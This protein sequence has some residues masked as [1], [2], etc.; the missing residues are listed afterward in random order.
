MKVMRGVRADD[1]ETDDVSSLHAVF[2]DANEDDTLASRIS[3]SIRRRLFVRG[4]VRVGRYL[5]EE[6]LDRGGL[7]VVWRGRDPDLARPVAIK[8]HRADHPADA[9]EARNSML[10]E[11][12]ALAQVRHP[13]VLAVFDVGLWSDDVYLVSELLRGRTLAT[14]LE[15][16][17]R[18]R[19]EIIDVFVAA[20]RGLAA[21][22]EAGLVH[23][24]F[25]PQN[26][27]IVDDGTP[28]VIDF[29]LAA[30]TS[31]DV[32]EAAQHTCG[33][34]TPRYMAPEQMNGEAVDA[35]ADVFAFCVSLYVALTDTAPFRGRT[36]RELRRAKLAGDLRPPPRGT[37]SR[38][39]WSI[40]RKG[41][42]SDPAAR[43]RSMD[44]LL[45]RLGRRT[46]SAWPIVAGVA[47]AIA[48]VGAT[49]AVL[50]ARDASSSCTSEAGVA[51]ALVDSVQPVDGSALTPS[52]HRAFATLDRLADAYAQSW[53]RHCAA[54]TQPREACLRGWLARFRLLAHATQSDVDRGPY[55]D[56]AIEALADPSRCEGDPLALDVAASQLVGGPALEARVAEAELAAEAGEAEA[57]LAASR[58]LVADALAA[59]HSRIA[60][61]ALLVEARVLAR[62][63]DE[64]RAVASF[65]RAYW[66]ATS[67]G[68]DE[69][70]VLA[71]SDLF[72]IAA[73][74]RDRDDYRRWRG[75]AD[76]ALARL[77]APSDARII[78]AHARYQAAAA[79]GEHAELAALGRAWIEEA[80]ALLGSEHPRTQLARNNLASSLARG[81]SPE[82]IDEALATLRALTQQVG[83]THPYTLDAAVNV[84]GAL[85]VNDRADEAVAI[86][87][88][89]VADYDAHSPLQRT[90]KAALLTNLASAYTDMQRYADSVAVTQRAL[91]LVDGVEAAR[92][93]RPA[94]LTNL[95][96]TEADLGRFEEAEQTIA[97]ALVEKAALFGKK[98][99]SYAFSMRTAGQIASRQGRYELA[100]SRFRESME[101]QDEL[102]DDNPERHHTAIDLARALFAQGRHQE[103][104][105]LASHALSSLESAPQDTTDFRR[106]DA[107][108]LLGDAARIV[109]EDHEAAIVHYV[110][111]M[112]LFDAQRTEPLGRSEAAFGLAQ[113]REALRRRASE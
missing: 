41:L 19:R 85:L 73:R 7:G 8:F 44:E 31:A 40:L 106:A 50:G 104:R 99:Q 33:S 6:E 111:A 37:M 66:S 21:A 78:Y 48:L 100:A 56:N 91:A 109:D 103:A 42:Q 65:E 98:S 32:D 101:L 34:G 90:R 81:G 67:I 28:K 61:R 18:S 46:S 74:A 26:V 45:D 93:V 54:E 108:A 110:E 2:A 83:E 79:L 70:S 35:R 3:S 64:D 4:P 92:F 16:S 72:R 1:G 24:D 96:N 23:R 68:D 62:N 29:G 14:W 69:G 87:E 71:A 10:H 80:E 97:R 82:R 57:A 59:G 77:D 43:W 55:V 88:R 107:H 52:R 63:H 30:E 84:T 27:F 38:G 22:H 51:T 11:A 60:V 9:A 102:G 86:L 89:V 49:A 25:K 36:F 58:D 113:S 12:Q 95:A 53:E 47:M 112:K 17:A 76:T 39:L 105:A 13:N 20:G 94:M 75:H 5:L 15:E